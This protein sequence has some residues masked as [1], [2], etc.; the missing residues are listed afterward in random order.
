MIKKMFITL[1]FILSSFVYGDPIEAI[2]TNGKFVLLY[3][4]GKWEY[5]R[6]ENI[7]EEFDFRKTYWGMSKENVKATETG[8]IIRD[9]DILA[10]E[11]IIGGLKA[12]IIYI[13]VDNKLVR[14]KYVFI[15]KHSNRNDYIH[16]Y[17]NLKNIL[18]KKYK[19]SNEDKVYWKNDLY[20][21]DYENWGL[22]ISIGHL[23]QF[24]NWKTD[25]TEIWLSLTGDNYSID[26]AVEYSSI[27]LSE[28]ENA[29][30]ETQTEAQF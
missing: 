20:E 24:S 19:Q 12:Y 25:K 29:K 30:R 23:T 5:T 26:L 13:F 10:Y 3:E 4:N 14:S 6:S 1:S 28:L 16:D 7:S 22:A 8:E 15:E 17:N 21:D 9:N 2:T 18:T 27:K 11:G